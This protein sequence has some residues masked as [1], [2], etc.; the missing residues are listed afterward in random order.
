MDNLDTL[1]QKIHAAH[2][3]SPPQN[4]STRDMSTLDD[5]THNFTGDPLISRG[6]LE[7]HGQVFLG[8]R[9]YTV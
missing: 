6:F 5:I 3:S 1:V 9:R 4:F 7:K 2:K 8:N